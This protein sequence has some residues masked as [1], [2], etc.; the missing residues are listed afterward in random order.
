MLDLL[1]ALPKAWPKGAVKGL[2]A[3]GGFEV[4]IA[5][6]N[7]R[8]ASAAVRSVTGKKCVMRYG[9]KTRE[10]LLKQGER[11]LVAF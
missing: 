2:R 3:R 7:G 9:E 8:L 6:K 11:R 1:P 10:L 5:W 4:D